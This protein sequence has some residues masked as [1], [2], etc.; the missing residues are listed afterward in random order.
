MEEF[1]ERKSG[2]SLRSILNLVINFNIFNPMRGNSYVDLPNFIKKKK[3]C[4][5]VANDDNECFKWAIL[6]ALHPAVKNAS[7][8]SSYKQFNN[9]LNFKGIKFPVGSGQVRKFE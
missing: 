2:W 6:S 9:E 7:R 4:V 8:V 1:Q 3:A 5:N